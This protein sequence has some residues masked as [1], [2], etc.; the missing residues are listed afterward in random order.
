VPHL[1]SHELATALDGLGSFVFALSG[2]LLAVEKRFDLF[3]V[4]VLSFVV[5]VAGG[6][7]RDLLI[8]AVPPAAIAGWHTL[9][10]AIVAGLLT[11]YVYPRVQSRKQDVLLFDALGLGVF[12]VTGTQKA[13]QFGID[14]VMSAVLGMVSGIGGGILR[15]ILAGVVPTVLRADLYAVAALA[16]GGIV[17][18]GSVL[19]ATS[20]GAMLLGGVVCIFLRTMAI[21]RGW[22]VPVARSRADD[23]P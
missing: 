23:D 5:A 16:A 14:P 12:A 11:F 18:M 3:G 10:I 4:L 2:G 1:S 7:T 6:V 22:H 20:R 17:S 9:A 8:G 15:D 21:Y 19:G 13:L